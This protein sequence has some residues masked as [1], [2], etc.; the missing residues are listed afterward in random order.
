MIAIWMVVFIVP[1]MISVPGWLEISSTILAFLST[2]AVLTIV[3][4]S[5]VRP[6]ARGTARTRLASVKINHDHGT[7]DR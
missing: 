6:P 7:I 2:L 1:S 3:S 4:V 5:S